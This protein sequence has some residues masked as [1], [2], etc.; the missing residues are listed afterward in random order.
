MFPHHNLR[1]WRGKIILC[2]A[3]QEVKLIICSEI[4]VELTHT[5][6]RIRIEH[7]MSFLHFKLPVKRNISFLAKSSPIQNRLPK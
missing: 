6:M 5:L 7:Y 3:E 1:N 2:N 4:N